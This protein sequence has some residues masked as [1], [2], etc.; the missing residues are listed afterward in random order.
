MQT[1]HWEAVTD[2]EISQG[3]GGRVTKLVAA[4]GGHLLFWP[5]LAG[6]GDH[7]SP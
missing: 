3:G 1:Q 2:P 6:S 5:V 4:H 7:G